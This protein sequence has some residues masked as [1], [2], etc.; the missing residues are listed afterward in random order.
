MSEAG[1]GSPQEAAPEAVAEAGVE[2]VGY[3]GVPP[4]PASR[5]MAITALSANARSFFMVC[6]PYVW[7]RPFAP[8]APEGL[9]RPLT[10]YIVTAPKGKNDRKNYALV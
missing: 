2:A 8:F 10:V 7:G 5:A 1:V 4:Q 3:A 6:P 9:F